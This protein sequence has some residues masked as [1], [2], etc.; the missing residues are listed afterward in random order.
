MSDH[1]IPTLGRG[2]YYAYYQI[3]RDPTPQGA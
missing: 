1:G 3:S 2:E